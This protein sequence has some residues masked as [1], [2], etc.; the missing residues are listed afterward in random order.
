MRSKILICYC[1]ITDSMDTSLSK[2]R[3]IVEDREAWS[4][5]V[6]GVAKSQTWLSN[7][8]NPKVEQ[9]SNTCR[10]S[11]KRVYNFMIL[12]ESFLLIWSL[13]LSTEQTLG[14]R[15][16]PRDLTLQTYKS[17]K[18]NN[19]SDEVQSYCLMNPILCLFHLWNP[20]LATFLSLRKGRTLH[21]RR[22]WRP[23][24]VLLPGKSHGWRSLLGCS[25]WGC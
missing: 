10:V 1:S 18:R 22:Q 23:T 16:G 4:A 13:C 20:F 6:R 8:N 12:Y 21:W 24:P 3:E 15:C 5:A 7:R 25:P 14:L 9:M 19:R 2:L 17:L 11:K